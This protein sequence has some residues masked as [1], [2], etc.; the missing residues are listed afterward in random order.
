MR[1]KSCIF[2]A[3]LSLLIGLPFTVEA[4]QNIN[5]LYE[6]AR[7]AEA[8]EEFDK[9]TLYYEDLYKKTNADAYYNLSLIHI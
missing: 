3:L 7:Q 8:N 5:T 4:Q 1:L 9:A 6:L 2:V